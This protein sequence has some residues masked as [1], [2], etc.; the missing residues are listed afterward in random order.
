VRDNA[1]EYIIGDSFF[2]IGDFGISIVSDFGV[3][4]PQQ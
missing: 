1:V 2:S 4:V 3:F